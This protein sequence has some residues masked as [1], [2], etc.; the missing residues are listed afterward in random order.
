MNYC[1]ST[2]LKSPMI[3]KTLKTLLLSLAVSDVG[4]GLLAQPLYISILAMW[5][6]QSILSSNTCNVFLVVAVLFSA[7]SFFGVVAVSVDRFLAIHLHLRYQELVTHKRVVA[8][9]ILIWVLSF[10]LSLMPLWA[11]P[12]I[13]SLFVRIIVVVGLVLTIMVYIRIYLAVRRHK[14]QIQ[15]LQVQ[16]VAQTDEMANF[17]SLVKSVVGIFY[18]YLLFLVCYLPYLISLPAFNLRPESFIEDIIFF[19]LDFRMS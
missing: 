13:R 3:S 4:V 16:Q 14:N 15:A 7:A 19:L 8:V 11:P 17:A 12:D 9:V 5:L 1:C 10:F 2:S 6:Q 18:V